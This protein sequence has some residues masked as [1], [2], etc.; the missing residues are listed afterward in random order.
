MN[1]KFNYIMQHIDL[2][3]DTKVN[4]I[5]AQINGK[6]LELRGINAYININFIVYPLAHLGQI[7]GELM[8]SDDFDALFAECERQVK[9]K[10][11][12]WENYTL[13]SKHFEVIEQLMPHCDFRF[14]MLGY[15]QP[16][17]IEAFICDV[18]GTVPEIDYRVDTLDKWSIKTSQMKLSRYANGLVAIGGMKPFNWV[19][20][21]N[22]LKSLRESMYI[23]V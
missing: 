12:T 22:T 15:P 8:E 13:Y 9:E 5:V 16:K 19:K 3:S 23:K 7:N 2:L 21:S 14:K 10:F 6:R 4:K 1:P 11:G 17:D 18:I 20:I